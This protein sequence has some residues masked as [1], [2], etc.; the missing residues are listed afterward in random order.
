M[1]ETRSQRCLGG[2]V[3]LGSQRNFDSDQAPTVRGLAGMGPLGMGLPDGTM[4]QMAGM[5]PR[6]GSGG[7]GT[8]GDG[9]PGWNDASD[10]GDG[11]S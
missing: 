8:P 4:R 10:G 7:D 2:Q 6:E 3:G 1:G 5:G 11:T 9:T